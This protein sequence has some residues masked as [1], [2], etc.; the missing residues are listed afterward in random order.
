MRLFCRLSSLGAIILPPLMAP[1]RFLRISLRS[2]LSP[3]TITPP[4]RFF[5][6]LAISS[7]TGSARPYSRHPVP[8]CLPTNVA[9]ACRADEVSVKLCFFVKVRKARGRNVA[10][11]RIIGSAPA[12]L[13]VDTG[14]EDGI[15]WRGV[16]KAGEEEGI[17]LT[18]AGV[19]VGGGLNTGAARGSS[20]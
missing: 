11:G 10:G 13:E 2:A 7:S 5:Q 12:L 3:P 9:R 15:G 17:S 6:L 14:S 4:F 16:A 1:S 20:G 18:G 19:G 8:Q